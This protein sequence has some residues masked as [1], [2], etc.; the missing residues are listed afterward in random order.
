MK[1]NRKSVCREFEKEVFLFQEGSLPEHRI[2][3]IKHHLEECARCQSIYKDVV[4]VTAEYEILPMD[5]LDEHSFNIRINNAINRE[6]KVN[7]GGYSQKRRSLVDMFG[8]YRLS[9]GGAAVAAAL[10][11]IIIS[12]L[13]EPNI[14]KKLPYELLDWNG[15]KIERKIEQIENQIISLKTDEWDIYIV[16]KNENENW[17]ATLKNIRNQIDKLKK[18]TNNKEL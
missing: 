5:D 14:E 3:L 2:E 17:D 1:N 13:N 9:L 7:A 10:I 18:T 4:K 6:V 8:F 15:N 16:R 12:F 11:L